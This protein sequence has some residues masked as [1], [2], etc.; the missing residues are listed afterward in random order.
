MPRSIP[1]LLRNGDSGMGRSRQDSVDL[2]NLD[3]DP[4]DYSM[5]GL[6]KM[7]LN[8]SRARRTHASSPQQPNR[9]IL[10]NLIS[11]NMSRSLFGDLQAPIGMM[12]LFG[13]RPVPRQQS[14]KDEGHWWGLLQS[15]TVLFFSFRQENLRRLLPN[16]NVHFQYSEQMQSRQAASSFPELKTQLPRGKLLLQSFVIPIWRSSWT[17]RT[18]GLQSIAAA[19]ISRRWKRLRSPKQ[20]PTVRV[21][22]HSKRLI[23]LI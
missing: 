9:L 1:D 15:V 14:G 2:D 11:L 6:S 8:E 19:G 10:L 3:F 23:R 18:A 17:R 22:I 16:V 20:P 7:Q 13:E 5:K 21:W 4:I 12:G